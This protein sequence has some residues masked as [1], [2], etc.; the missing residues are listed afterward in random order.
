[1]LKDGGKVFPAWCVNAWILS[2]YSE[3]HLKVSIMIATSFQNQALNFVNIYRPSM[4]TPYKP[5]NI[6]WWIFFTP[7]N[8][9]L[10]SIFHHQ[11]LFVVTSTLH[12]NY[13][14]LIWLIPQV[15]RHMEHEAIYTFRHTFM[16]IHLIS[17]SHKLIFSH[18]S[19]A[20]AVF[21]SC[22]V[23]TYAFLFI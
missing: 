19:N 21:R 9:Y 18:W 10:S 11:Q 3:L 12:R 15:V 4:Q 5:L 8:H 2:L 6:W 23:I 17:W 14:F 7:W 22:S 16:V 20:A 13:F 1:M